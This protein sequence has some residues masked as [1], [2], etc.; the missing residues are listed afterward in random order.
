VTTN[1]IQPGIRTCLLSAFLALALFSFF[2]FGSGSAHA[3]TRSANAAQSA[4]SS[5]AVVS[6]I[7]INKSGALVYSPSAITVKSG[8]TV[9]IVNKTAFRR[10]LFMSQGVAYLNPAASM[11]II[12][13]QSQV[14]G[15]CGGGSLTITVL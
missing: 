1:R 9:K 7:I 11:A 8:T 2:A 3:M 4:S 13:T 10:I 15:L 5:T 14:V 6:R 12:V